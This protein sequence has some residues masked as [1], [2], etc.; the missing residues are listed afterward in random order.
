MPHYKNLEKLLQNIGIKT[1]SIFRDNIKKQPNY[2]SMESL[3]SILDELKI[4]NISVKLQAEQLS[5]ISFPTI[6]HIE[7]E[8]E[9]YFVILQSINNGEVH[10][11]DTDKGMQTLSLAEFIKNWSGKTILLSISMVCILTSCNKTY[12][13]EC[14]NSGGVYATYAISGKKNRAAGECYDIG[15]ESSNGSTQNHCHL[16]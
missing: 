1:T 5:K 2:P 13:C 16:K 3:I 10:F 12:Q 11:Y 7:K 8:E 4:S 14:S 9:S 15:K 6:A